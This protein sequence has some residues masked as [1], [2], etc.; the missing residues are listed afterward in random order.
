MRIDLF[1]R[2]AQRHRLIRRMTIQEWFDKYAEHHQNSVNVVIHWICVPAI[3]I[4]L[5][6]LLAD[7]PFM[8]VARQFPVPVAMFIHPG[9]ILIVLGLLFYVRLSISI[10]IG[11]FLWCLVVLYII[12]WMDTDLLQPL[13]LINLI[14]FV[15]A[16]IGQFIGHKI[17]GAKPSFMD[18]LKFLMI[19]PAWLLSKIYKKVGIPL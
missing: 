1:N 18:D 17:E 11:M 7:I 2:Q 8:F 9:T 16:W 6:G 14:I 3:F 5:I 15:V 12:Y 10:T 13:W 4:S 19:G